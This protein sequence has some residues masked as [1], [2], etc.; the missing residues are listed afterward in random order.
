MNLNN[1]DGL[2]R[3]S[4]NSWLVRA[5]CPNFRTCEETGW[6]PGGVADGYGD[7][8][9]LKKWLRWNRSNHFRNR[10]ILGTSNLPHITTT[11][12][13]YSSNVRPQTHNMTEMASVET[14]KEGGYIAC[15]Q[16]SDLIFADKNVKLPSF[17][18]I[19]FWPAL[20]D[21]WST[22][23]KYKGVSWVQGKPAQVWSK[24]YENDQATSMY[25]NDLALLT[26]RRPNRNANY[27]S[28]DNSVVKPY[29]LFWFPHRH[30]QQNI[31]RKKE[32]R[33]DKDKV[34]IYFILFLTVGW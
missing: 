4:V 23:F 15:C 22:A 27:L 7:A 21:I 2:A 33:R 31:W 13:I 28:S 6:S 9:K 16:A 34:S 11:D 10:V 32:M 19:N 12:E 1:N 18:Q 29:F 25:N 24:E 8:R 30:S 5:S 14:D 26:R 3:C 17:V 20:V